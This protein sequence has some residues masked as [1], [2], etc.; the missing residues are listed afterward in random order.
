M[1][2]KLNGIEVNYEVYGKEGVLWFIFSYL[3]VCSLK[4]WELQFVV[5]KDC[6]CILF[7]DIC[8]YGG[9]EVLKGLYMLEMLVEDL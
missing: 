7:Y 3:F 4:M 2:I 9:I 6:F 8:G 1:K 5:F